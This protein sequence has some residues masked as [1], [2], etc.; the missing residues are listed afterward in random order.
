M[1][2]RRKHKRYDVSQHPDLLGMTNRSP[3]GERLLTMS[4][5]GCGFAS[6]IDDFRFKVGDVIECQFRMGEGEW[7]KVQGAVLYTNPY[8]FNGEI[9][10]FYGVRF[11]GDYEPSIRIIIEA[12]EALNV[13][14][15][16][17]LA[18]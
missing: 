16:L 13:Q 6:L 3:S 14:G 7:I 10:R 18:R 15:K 2:E 11:L 5:A 1:R 17:A 4:L 9:G 12:L 8:P